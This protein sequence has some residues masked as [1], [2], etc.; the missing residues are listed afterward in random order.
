MK[1]RE[2]IEVR[3]GQPNIPVVRCVLLAAGLWS[4]REHLSVAVLPYDDAFITFNIC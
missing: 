2:W 3:A 4:V 1:R